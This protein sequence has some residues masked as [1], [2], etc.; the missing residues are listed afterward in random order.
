MPNQL[1]VERPRRGYASIQA[2]RHGFY[3]RQCASSW[4]ARAALSANGCTTQFPLEPGKINGCVVL[5]G[6]HTEPVTLGVARLGSSSTSVR[7]ARNAARSAL[8]VSCESTRSERYT[9]IERLG[10]ELLLATPAL[11]PC[12]ECPRRTQRLNSLVAPSRCIQRFTQRMPGPCFGPVHSFVMWG[13]ML[14]SPRL[15]GNGIASCQAG[16]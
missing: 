15:V 14:H 7:P 1:R 4:E 2:H 10:F 8:R 9:A 12:S 6:P 5:S 3:V 16:R 13:P 11:E